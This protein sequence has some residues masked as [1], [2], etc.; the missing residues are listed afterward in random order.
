MKAVPKASKEKNRRKT[1]F[2][3]IVGSSLYKLVFNMTDVNP[4]K[5]IIETD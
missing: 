2:V 1:S 4:H 3:F 5:G